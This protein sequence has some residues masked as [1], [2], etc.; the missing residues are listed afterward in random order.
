LRPAVHRW[1][2]SP[3]ALSTPFSRPDTS[4][5]AAIGCSL[6]PHDRA[7]SGLGDGPA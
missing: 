6:R 5:L 2:S 4:F 3:A 7:P 1:L